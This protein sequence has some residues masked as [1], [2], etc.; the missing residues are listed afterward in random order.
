MS[1]F[2][3]DKGKTSFVLFSM[4][5]EKI[6]LLLITLIIDFYFAPNTI[7][8]HSSGNPLFNNNIFD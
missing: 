4:P 8:N 1:N 3:G 7:L 6:S 2:S 5:G